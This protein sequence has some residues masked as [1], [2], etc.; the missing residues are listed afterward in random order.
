MRRQAGIAAGLLAAVAAGVVATVAVRG[1]Q[2]PASPPAAPPVTTATVV[3]TNLATTVLTAGT[4]GYAAT[5][6]VVNQMAGTY[7]ALPTP[8]QAIRAGQDL[9]Q[10]DNL[11]VVLM[12]GGTP[13]WR[14]FAAGMTGGP[15][16]TELQRNL[17]M[18]GYA[19]GLLTAPTGQ[20]DALT[21]DAV[22][23]W[24][25]AVGYPATGQ[26]TLGQ[27]VFLPVG[28]IVGGLNQ[29]PGQLASPG[30]VPFDVTAAR[31][32]VTVAFGPDLPAVALGEA[33]SI[34]LPSGA[35]TPGTITAI[36]PPPPAGD[37]GTNGSGK[38]GTS[39]SSGSGG[40][41]GSS[42]SGGS[43]GTSLELTITPDR[44]AATG[45]GQ[46]VAVQV[47]LVTQS[48]RNVLAVPV[49]A[50]LA[51]AG[52]GYGVELAGPNGNHRLVG[53]TTGLFANTLVEVSG[54]DIQAGLKV[55]TAQ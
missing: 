39:G 18:L 38:D 53:V 6:P 35:A 47:S 9:Y 45:T 13:A 26:V 43:S 37:A 34:V 33:V 36:G 29:A 40:T 52:G 44:S 20:F 1:S 12:R 31:R 2:N 21:E 11:P 51:L 8:G 23:R 25:E 15:D 17:I 24:Q 30:Q 42:G 3:R 28:I 22:V 41:S 49:T 7:T 4:L 32:M 46:D 16:V 27:V 10:V 14:T 55:V 48:V 19:A 50:L 54:P 5:D